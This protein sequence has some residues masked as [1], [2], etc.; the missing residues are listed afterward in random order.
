MNIGKLNKKMFSKISLIALILII[1][2]F[3]L[4]VIS[5]KAGAE[6]EISVDVQKYVDK[7]S[8]IQNNISSTIN[9]TR[10]FSYI[11][12]VYIDNLID[13]FNTYNTSLNNFA[14]TVVN[15]ICVSY[16]K[17]DNVLI[18]KAMA[19]SPSGENCNLTNLEIF[20]NE[21]I[22][23]YHSLIKK[24]FTYSSCDRLADLIQDNIILVNTVGDIL[25]DNDFLGN[26]DL[27]QSLEDRLDELNSLIADLELI[28]ANIDSINY[29]NHAELTLLRKQFIDIDYVNL[30]EDYKIISNR[31]ITNVQES[32]D[33][34]GEISGEASEIISRQDSFYNNERI[35][36][37]VV[38]RDY[39]NNPLAGLDVK[40]SANQNGQIVGIN[41]IST[42]AQTNSQGRAF[43]Q[44][45]V[46]NPGSLSYKADV[47]GLEI[48]ADDLVDIK[49]APDLEF[50]SIVTDLT[51]IQIGQQA[52]LTITIRD[53]YNNIIA[54]EDFRVGT[55]TNDPAV[56]ISPVVGMTDN[57]GQIFLRVSR[58]D[59]GN[60]ALVIY[61]ANT[62]I[63][64]DD[65]IQ[66]IALIS[67]E[68]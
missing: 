37:E 61:I 67:P 65:I 4:T 44:L 27:E 57:N 11:P 20:F 51:E 58:S 13:D 30:V 60:I 17:P 56:S 5:N 32:L 7:V 28:V 39:Q 64:V 3:S 23:E 21:T 53:V 35:P 45:A 22:K 55:I 6:N 43:F 8:V 62:R 40:L 31:I 50:S 68:E 41:I 47:D 49:Q 9:N 42:I 54:G 12:D 46:E 25:R 59:S 26:N 38:V 1:S 14:E 16:L 36:V 18:K 34:F 15:E 48:S 24:V 10:N 63:I 2:F 19:S 29:N 52:H 33:L 66:V